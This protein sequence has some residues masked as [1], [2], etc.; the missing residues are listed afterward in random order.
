MSEKYLI[1]G[2]GRSGICS[3]QLLENLDKDALVKIMTEPK[4]ALVKQYKTMFKI[5]GVELD[6]QEDAVRAVAKKAMKLKTGARGL[7]TIMEDVMLDIM[8]ITPDDRTI[9]KVVVNEETVDNHQP[10]IER[11]KDRPYMVMLIRIDNNIFAFF[12]SL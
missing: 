11:K 12:I 3:A 4:N 2:A 8:F 5:D 1:V 7:R 10:E 9:S 6:I